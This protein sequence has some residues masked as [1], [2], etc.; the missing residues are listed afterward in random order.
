[1]T[2]A[3]LMTNDKRRMGGANQRSASIIRPF[4]NSFVIGHPYFVIKK[5]RKYRPPHPMDVKGGCSPQNIRRKL[6]W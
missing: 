2:N 4:P 5:I 1:M 3:E 6:R